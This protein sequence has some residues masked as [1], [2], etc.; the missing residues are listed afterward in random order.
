M[1]ALNV[2]FRT[3]KDLDDVADELLRKYALWKKGH[4]RPPINVDEIVEGYLRLVLEVQDLQEMLGMGDVLGAAW[5]D[6]GVIRVDSRIEDQEGRFAFTVA[7]E[8]GHWQIHRPILEMERVTLP[9]FPVAPG[10]EPTPALVCRSGGER[11]REEIQADRF[12][13]R[14]LMPASE[15]RRAFFDLHKEGRVGFDNLA[16]SR[17]TRSPDPRV[18]PL[19]AE[20]I[21][22]G[23]FTN[24]S[25]EAMAWR[26]LDLGLV[27]DRASI[28]PSLF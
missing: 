19:A 3:D 25:R 26:L 10:A 2:P 6:D 20:M 21:A 4:I 24:V 5:F 27:V 1:L 28:P 22:E 13:A 16:D 14:L 15:V 18:R 12:A 11:R 23:G 8:I 9:L 7:H 17:K